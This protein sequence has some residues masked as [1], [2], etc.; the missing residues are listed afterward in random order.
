MALFKSKAE[1]RI[2]RTIQIQRTL[3]MFTRQIRKL[4]KQEEGYI[5]A[6]REAM[7]KSAPAQLSLAKK[8]LKATMVQRRRLDHQM[9]TLKLASQMK[10]QAETHAEF[11]K[12][13]SSTSRAISE[14]FGEIDLARAEK[15]FHKAMAQANSIEERVDCFL[16]SA[17]TGMFGEATGSDDLVSD[18]EIDQ[19]IEGET[20]KPFDGEI[21]AELEAIEKELGKPAAEGEEGR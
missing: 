8:A 19:L 1:R 4:G 13:L 14:T 17:S 16:E 21:A 3:G 7:R 2:E 11:A 12:A 5:T 18:S 20:A 6:A 15:E 9:L 10:D